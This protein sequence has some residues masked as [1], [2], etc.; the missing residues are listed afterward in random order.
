[1][2]VYK[3][4]F[5]PRKNIYNTVS[6]TEGSMHNYATTIEVTILKELG[7]LAL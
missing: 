3:Y 6:S 5:R 2:I 7:K 1:M 4:V